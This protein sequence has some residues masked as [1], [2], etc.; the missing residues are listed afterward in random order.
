MFRALRVDGTVLSEGDAVDSGKRRVTLVRVFLPH[1]SLPPARSVCVCVCQ[2]VCVCVC[3]C[4]SVCLSVH[5]R[6]C[7]CV[8]V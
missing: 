4:V 1:S 6:E 8:C 3:V 5:A 2:C 7:V